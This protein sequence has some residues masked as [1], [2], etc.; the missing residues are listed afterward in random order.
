LKSRITRFTPRHLRRLLEIEREVFPE[1][2]YAREL[3]LELYA[4]CGALFFIAHCAGEVAGYSVACASK[5]KAELV[6]I[7]VDPRF[8]GRGIGSALLG[9]TIRALQAQ[10]VLSLE[11]AVR[12]GNRQ[13]ITFYAHRSFERVARIRRYYEDGGDAF[14]MVLRLP[15]EGLIQ[16]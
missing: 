13:A 8:R 11:L 12:V 10:S 7:G 3:F 16:T 6:S 4:D 14:R 15:P 9:R 5:R 1:D 2:A